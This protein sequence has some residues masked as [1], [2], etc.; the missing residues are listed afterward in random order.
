MQHYQR[1]VL[2]RRPEGEV[3]ADDFRLETCARPTLHDGEVLVRND[4][5]SLDPYMR[6]RMSAGKSYAQPQPLDE[7]M[8]GGTV[9]EIIES[10]HPDWAVGE[11]VQAYGGWQTLSVLN[12]DAHALMTRIA[13][14]SVPL[15]CYLGVLG[16]P[17]Q[18]AWI[19]LTDLLQ[20]K[21][22]QT[23]VVSAAAGA[24]GSVVGQLARLRG[25]RAIGVA[26]GADKC[27]YVTETL[28]FDACIDY[29]AM[30]D[31]TALTAA[32]L[33]AAPQGVD[34][35]F[36]NVGGLVLDGV[37][38][39]MNPFGRVAIC[40]MISGYNREPIP[41][42]N[43]LVILRSRLSI[44]GFIVF[45]HRD[46]VPMAQAELISHVKAKRL[47]YSETIA[48]GLAAAPQAFMGL[49]KGQNLG[50]QLVAL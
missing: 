17:G 38:E 25:C 22:G 3:R 27:R 35:Y 10:K 19:G 26:G 33:A 39:A 16:M 37:L 28:G 41:L 5:L 29:R 20:A 34:A 15:S 12:R 24:V 40:G 7:P 14:A 49:L 1:I 43:P 36:D 6:G 21:A 11:R 48:Q 47:R 13:D 46:R 30:K 8:I 9:G 45:E 50:K 2:A 4:F 44:Q 32:V 18:T 42:K 31:S 23:V